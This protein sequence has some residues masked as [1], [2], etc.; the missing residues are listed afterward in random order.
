MSIGHLQR[1]VNR[2]CHNRAAHSCFLCPV[3]YICNSIAGKHAGETTQ[4]AR[5]AGLQP[6]VLGSFLQ[7]P[8]AHGHIFVWGGAHMLKR[9]GEIVWI[10]S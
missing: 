1:T 7:L 4:W 8:Q 9:I 6:I 2:P 10:S 3:K 5:R